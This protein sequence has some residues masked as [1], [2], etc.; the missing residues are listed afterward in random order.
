VVR[1]AGR[2]PGRLDRF[3]ASAVRGTNGATTAFFSPDGRS[4]GFITSA[5]E[6]RTMTLAEGVVTTAARGASVLYG[7]TWS[8]ADQL[9]YVHDAVLW[10]VSRSVA[11]RGGHTGHGSTSP[12]AH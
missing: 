5:G 2:V 12:A 7:A 9:V 10:R 11:H 6:L 3:E 4:L 1:A 8:D